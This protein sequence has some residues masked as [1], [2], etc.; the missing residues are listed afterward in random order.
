MKI[1]LA[2]TFPVPA[3]AEAAWT[4]LGDVE[5]VAACMPGARI[6]ARLDERHYQ[7][8]VS[9][10]LGPA[11]LAFRGE[12]EVLAL[13]PASRTLRL[14]GKGTDTTGGSGASL[15]LTA[16]VDPV[17]GASCQLVGKSEV[18]MSGKVA[19]FGGRVADSVAQQVLQ[20]FVANFCAALTAPQ[21]S[22]SDAADAAAGSTA[23]AHAPRA[24]Q[25]NAL[26]LLWGV[27]VGWLRALFS[28]RGA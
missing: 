25:L 21:P 27:I 19:A 4:L 11:S 6:T 13:E 12:L 23:P 18:S 16:R 1:I 28:P 14:L 26:A 10:R 3:P 9:V 2:R 24:S 15:D 7:G 5:R 17:D 22:A 8:T 20:Q